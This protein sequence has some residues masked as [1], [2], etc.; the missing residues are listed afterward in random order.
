MKTNPC[1]KF[2]TVSALRGKLYLA[3]LAIGIAA[4]CAV[5]ST[6]GNGISYDLTLTENSSTSL[7]LAYTGPGGASS[8]SVLNTS[9]DH[10]TIT[11]L[12]QTISFSNFEHDWAE[13]EDPSLRFVNVVSHSTDVNDKLFV[14]SDLLAIFDQGGPVNPDGTPILVGQDSGTNVFLAFRDIAA[15]N[16]AGVSESGFTL[17]LFAFSSIALFGARRLR[18][19]R[20]A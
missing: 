19:S 1:A 17:S 10:W 14:I 2:E 11:I 9:A 15:T 18:M 12:S 6:Y 8:F 7:S 5:Q 16:E 3:L 20:S 13:P 4:T